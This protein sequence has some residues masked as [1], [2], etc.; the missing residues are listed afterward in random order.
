MVNDMNS[1]IV[2]PYSVVFELDDVGWHDGRDLRLKGQASRSGIPRDHAI[3]DYEVLDLIG[4]R[5]GNKTTVAIPLGDWDKDNLLR[6]EVGITHDPYG[7]DRASTIDLDHTRKC[8]EAL[9]GSEYLE[10]AYHGLLHGVYGADGSRINEHD[11]TVN[12]ILPDGTRITK[13]VDNL[14]RRIELW[15]KIYESWGFKKPVDIFIVGGGTAGLTDET[16]DEMTAIIRDY[17]FKYWTNGYFPFK[18]PI[19]VS[20]GVICLPQYGKK[21]RDYSTWNVYDDDPSRYGDFIIPGSENNSCVFGMHWTNMLRFNPEN[22][23]KVVEPWVDYFNRQSEVFGSMNARD[24][25]SSANQQ[26][27]TSFAR[28]NVEGNVCAIDLSDVLAKKPSRE[29]D[30]FFVSVKRGIA[31]I[32]CVGG[33]LTLYEEHREFNTYKIAHNAT[34]VTLLLKNV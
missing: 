12:E 29:S 4:R 20:N 24:F 28:M 10:Y 17:G 3:E 19:G 25:A 33:A 13:A 7:W 14:R 15:F 5:T 31:P 32:N 9:E 1:K 22:N 16:L 26:F 6:G 23:Y 34:R 8:M 18:G 2:I 21:G 27:Y 11:S 30:E